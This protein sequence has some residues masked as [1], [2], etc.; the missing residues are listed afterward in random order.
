MNHGSIMDG[1]VYLGLLYY[2][3]TQIMFSTL[4][5]IGGTVMK[6]PVFLKQRDFFIQRGHMLQP[7]LFLRS[8]SLLLKSRSGLLRLTTQ[9]DLAHMLGGKLVKLNI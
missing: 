6:L 7:H 1:E 9:L 5:D 8:L 3:M 2:T 4:G